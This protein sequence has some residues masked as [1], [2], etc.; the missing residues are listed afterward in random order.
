[1][2][3]DQLFPND[4]VAES[5]YGAVAGVETIRQLIQSVKLTG[6]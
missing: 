3:I 4:V 6:Y 1:M 5:A 2:L